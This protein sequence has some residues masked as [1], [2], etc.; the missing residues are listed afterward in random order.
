MRLRRKVLQAA[1]VAVL[2]ASAVAYGALEKHVTVR[3][4]GSL[5]RVHTFASSVGEVLDRAHVT[6]EP[7][8]LVRP[9]LSTHVREGML[10]EVRRAKPITLLLNG[11]PRQMIVTGLTVEEVIEQMNL[12]SSLADFVG[13]SRS[14]RIVA[15]VVLVYRNAVGSAVAHDGITQRVITN[16]SSIR[17]LL[18]EL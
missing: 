16:A 10:I 11:R 12:R 9:P 2:A 1:V 4:D 14:A 5:I 6:L 8:D 15:G 7:N 13:T 3:D 17:Q 18:V